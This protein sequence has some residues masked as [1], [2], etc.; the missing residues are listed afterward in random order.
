MATLVLT[1]IGDDRPGL[2]DA[3]SGVVTDHGGNWDRSHLARL[4]GKFAGIV[5]VE[6]PDSA[7]D[8]MIA[9][10]APL[11]EERLLSITVERAPGTEPADAGILV[12]LQL[13]GQDRPG[14]V[15]EISHALASNGVSIEELE[16]ETMSAPMAGERLFEATA[17]LRAPRDLAL[18]ELR[19]VLE[20]LA[21]ELMVDIDLT[22]ER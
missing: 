13:I 19:R 14:I 1:V 3:L 4:G 22:P 10:L 6:I 9:D 17:V 15:H 8:A 7:A 12:A 21:N 16:T 11:E 5:V 18:D 2:V 20:S